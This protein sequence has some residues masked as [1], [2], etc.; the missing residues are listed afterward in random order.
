MATAPATTIEVL[1]SDLEAVLDA[2]KADLA[3]QRK[4][5]KAARARVRRVTRQR[6]H[7][8]YGEI[9]RAVSDTAPRVLVYA[10]ALAGFT[11]FGIALVLLSI[12]N[13]TAAVTLFTV[14]GAAW[15]MGAVVR[16]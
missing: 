4:Q 2:A 11:A 9:T 1:D 15:G 5:T 10:L 12:G 3:R 7:T 13:A 8:R 6:R 14:A 16:R